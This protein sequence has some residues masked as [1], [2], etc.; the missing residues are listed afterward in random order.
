MHDCVGL[1]DVYSFSCM[2]VYVWV[3]MNMYKDL[4]MVLVIDNKCF[5]HGV[6]TLDLQIDFL[7]WT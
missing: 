5:I 3:H 1:Y 6:R 2:F 7:D 4:T